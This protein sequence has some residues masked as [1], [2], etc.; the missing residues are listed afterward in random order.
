[1]TFFFYTI[2]STLYLGRLW[3][4]FHG[5]FGNISRSNL[6]GDWWALSKYS[7]ECR[8]HFVSAG[9]VP[10]AVGLPGI[11]L[12]WIDERFACR[13]LLLLYLPRWWHHVDPKSVL[14]NH[15]NCAH[16]SAWALAEVYM[17]RG[18]GFQRRPGIRPR[19]S[20]VGQDMATDD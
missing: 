18:V 20:D 17:H 11:Q 6:S 3:Q 7:T 1:M 13:H 10:L 12:N 9:R 4:Q 5:C 16:I 15:N 8:L 2:P 19:G 14:R